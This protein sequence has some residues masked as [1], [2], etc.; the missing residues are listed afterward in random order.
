MTTDETLVCGCR[1]QVDRSG[2]GHCWVDVAADDLPGQVRE[3]IEGEI[4]DHRREEGQMTGPN[5]LHY[6]WF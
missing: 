2:V 3:E 1:V 4:L 5:G 6:R